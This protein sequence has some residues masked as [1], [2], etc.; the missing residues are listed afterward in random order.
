MKVINANRT[1]TTNFS[2]SEFLH[3]NSCGTAIAKLMEYK[4][5]CRIYRPEGRV[6]YQILLVVI[7]IVDVAIN[8]DTH[9]LKE[10]DCVIFPPGVVQDYTFKA[11]S[12]MPQSAAYFVHFSGTAAGELMQKAALTELNVIRSVSGDVKR[13]FDAL[14]LTYKTKDEIT[15]IGNLFRIISLL[16]PKNNSKVSESNRLVRAEFDYINFHYV[17]KIDLDAC[18]ARCNLSRSRFTHIF[19][20]IFGTPPSKYQLNIRL[21]HAQQL[22]RYSSLTVGEIAE[23]CG[24]QDQLYFSKL[25]SRTFGIPPSRYR[26][27]R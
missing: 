2:S 3:I 26:Y 8:G 24:F 1:D 22:L 20:E 17:E 19:T 15:A 23:Q 4:G 21:E 14:F 27:H 5:D 11:N 10:N 25:F 9:T 13:I 16:S 7:G 12:S 6:D 18:A